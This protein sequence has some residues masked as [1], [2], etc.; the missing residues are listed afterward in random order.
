MAIFLV[1]PT[2]TAMSLSLHGYKFRVRP[3]SNEIDFLIPPCLF[4][5]SLSP[6][7]LAALHAH[8]RKIVPQDSAI[9][10][11]DYRRYTSLVQKTGLNSALVTYLT[12]GNQGGAGDIND[13]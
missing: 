7:I 5:I 1:L 13:M 9:P 6:Q 2:S 12:K 10:E 8:S 11:G 4:P 3:V